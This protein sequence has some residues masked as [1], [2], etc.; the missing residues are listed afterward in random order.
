MA[1]TLYT[2]DG[3]V[4]TVRPSNGKFWTLEEKQAI[5]GGYFELKRTLTGEY[6]VINETGKI[7]SPMLPLNKWATRIYQH[8]RTDPLVGEVLVVDTREEL[9]EPDDD[10]GAETLK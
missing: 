9:E 3:R 1:S 6:M 8:G 2:T 4:K 7:Q 5:V 10:D